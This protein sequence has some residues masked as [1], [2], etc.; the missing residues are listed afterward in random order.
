MPKV[1]NLFEQ[2]KLVNSKAY[3]SLTPKMKEA[4]EEMFKMINN[5]GNI[6]F[7][8]ENAVDRVAEIKKINKDELYQYIEK[9]TNEQLGV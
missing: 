5:K 8:V 1:S 9:E 4:V 6:I 2:K 3:N 7:N